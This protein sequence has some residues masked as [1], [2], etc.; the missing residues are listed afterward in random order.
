MK[1]IGV[2]TSGG[3]APG[4]NAAIRSVTRVSLGHGLRVIGFKHGY[5]G[6]LNEQ[7]DQLDARCVSNI[8]QR[9]GTILKTARSSEFCTKKGVQKA[10]RI[11][12]KLQVDGLVL[13]GG[14]GTFRGGMDLSKE[15]EG[16][17][18]GISGTIDNDLFG[19][20]FTLGFD[21]AVNTAIDAVDKIRDTAEAHERFFIVEVMGRHCGQIAMSAALATGA[22]EVLI[23]EKKV[24]LDDICRRLCENR[25][26]G[27]SS[28]LI[29]VAEGAVSGGAYKVAHDLKKRSK[30]EYRVC[31]LGHIR[32]G[33]SPNA[34]DRLF[35]SRCGAYAV[36]ALL[37]GENTKMVG[38]CGGKKAL[39]S[40][41]IAV[42]GKKHIASFDLNLMRSLNL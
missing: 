3:D 39:T 7:Y 32:R 15:W 8:L 38:E 2:L 40:F 17:L 18:V 28:S 34:A 35:G 24:E 13:I 20:D 16:K 6:V 14:D 9:G 27:K 37:A 5:E 26:R 23:P 41:R 10:A 25:D 21:T 11:L 4:M 31:I 22:E 36:E 19:T 33:G 30:N 12:N 29:I 42:K 1:T